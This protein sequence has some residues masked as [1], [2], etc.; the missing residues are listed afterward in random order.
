[1]VCVGAAMISGR[2]GFI[3]CVCVL[4]ALASVEGAKP[5]RKQVRSARQSVAARGPT[6][7]PTL[8]GLSAGPFANMC[9]RSVLESLLTLHNA[10]AAI[11]R[12]QGRRTSAASVID[13]VA[14]SFVPVE[15]LP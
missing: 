12:A 4:L 9:F 6:W 2:T 15:P 8:G 13:E 11:M 5:K 3:L 7:A 1:M 14:F 10:S